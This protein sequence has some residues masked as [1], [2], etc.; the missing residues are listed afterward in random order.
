MRTIETEGFV[1]EPQVAAHAEAMFVVLSD[2]ALY[3]HENEP[4]VSV[5]SLRERFARL[6][7]RRSRHGTQAWLNWVIRLPSGEFIGYVQATVHPNRQA[8]I[9]YVLSSVHWGKGLAHQAVAAMLGELVENHDVNSF[10]AVLKRS[11]Q[12]SLRLLRRLGFVQAPPGA[13]SGDPIESDELLMLR[14][15]HIE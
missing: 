9:A 10:S 6:E 4:P 11:N 3:E 7:T 1:L 15:A 2:P 12:R 14:E 8:M 5:Q 13:L